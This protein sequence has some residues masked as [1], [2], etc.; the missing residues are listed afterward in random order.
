MILNACKMKSTDELCH[1]LSDLLGEKE[2]L[3]EKE[4]EEF[5]EISSKAKNINNCIVI[6]DKNDITEIFR[7]SFN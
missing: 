3:S 2:K 7:K 1:K 6:I 5:S 4:I